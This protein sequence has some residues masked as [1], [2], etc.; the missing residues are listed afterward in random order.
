L[1]NDWIGYAIFG[2]T[3]QHI[4]GRDDKIILMNIFLSRGTADRWRGR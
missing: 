3:S 1:G 2:I 4:I